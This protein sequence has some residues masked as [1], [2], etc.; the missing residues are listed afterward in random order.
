MESSMTSQM[1]W[2]W[3]GKRGW[4]LDEDYSAVAENRPASPETEAHE[5]WQPENDERE[6]V[7]EAV[8]LMGAR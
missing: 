4:H 7:L 6:D 8:E 2:V 3:G 1:V 5:N